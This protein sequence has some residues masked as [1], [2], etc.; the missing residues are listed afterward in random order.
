MANDMG[1]H[2]GPWLLRKAPATNWLFS[3]TGSNA[4]EA[5]SN[6]GIE[7]DHTAPSSPRGTQVIGEIPNLLGPELTAQMTYY[8]TARG[9]K[10]FSAGA[11]TLAGSIRQKPVARLVENIWT[12]IGDSQDEVV[13]LSK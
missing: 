9:S 6:A 13:P 12:Q 10:V 2:R 7:I 8:S 1:E 11:F 3:G 5:F 4:G